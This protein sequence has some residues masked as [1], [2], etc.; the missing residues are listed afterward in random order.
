[1]Q[2]WENVGTEIHTPFNPKNQSCDRR[3]EGTPSGFSPGIG[4]LLIFALQFLHDAYRIVQALL[5]VLQIYLVRCVFPIP[6]LFGLLRLG[7][8]FISPVKN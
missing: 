5:L 6:D 1:M 2:T 8:H 3:G 7:S 4:S